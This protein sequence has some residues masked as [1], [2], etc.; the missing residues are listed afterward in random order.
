MFHLCLIA[1][2]LLIL[3]SCTNNCKPEIIIKT[4]EVLVPVKGKVPKVICENADVNSSQIE[5]IVKVL[6][7]NIKLRKTIMEYNK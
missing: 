3:T 4:K 6:E 2:A 1:F 5:V 7:C